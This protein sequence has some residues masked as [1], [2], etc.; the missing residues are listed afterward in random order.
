MTPQQFVSQL[1]T[2]RS[3]NAFNPYSDSCKV[4]DLDNA[5][6][7]RSKMLTET[8][9]A[10]QS[11]ELETLWIGR[12][13]GYRGGRRTGLPFTDDVHLSDHGARWGLSVSRPTKGSAVAERAATVIW[14]LLEAIDLPIFLWN[15]FPLHPHEITNPFTNRLHTAAERKLGLEVL[16][17][18][19]GLVRPK[20]LLAIGNDAAKAVETLG[21][22]IEVLRVRHPSYGG[23]PEFLR[24]VRQ[25]YGVRPSGFL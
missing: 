21:T 5:P 18:L 25:I 12:D 8:L 23:Q 10:A 13:L 17:Q 20:K 19:I 22:G 6:A 2:Q 9:V 16:E 11:V 4:Y 1:S 15:V 7:I 24:D 14:S 3:V